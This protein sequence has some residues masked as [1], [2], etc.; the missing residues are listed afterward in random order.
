VSPL[1]LVQPISAQLDQALTSTLAKMPSGK[2]RYVSGAVTT[3]GIELAAGW[4]PTANLNLSAYAA[5][6]Y[7]SAWLAGA[8][9]VWS[10]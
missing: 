10:W 3:R 4:K 5:K 2:P 1:A 9:S 6:E 7:G 8:R